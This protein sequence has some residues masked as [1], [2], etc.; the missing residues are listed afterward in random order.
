MNIFFFSLVNPFLQLGAPT[1]EGVGNMWSE[2]GGREYIGKPH[3]KVSATGK[4]VSV[5]MAGW[6]RNQWC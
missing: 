3:E 4:L 1:M 2:G 6:Q 5:T